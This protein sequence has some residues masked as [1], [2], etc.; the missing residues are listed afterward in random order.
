MKERAN[1]LEQEWWLCRIEREGGESLVSFSAWTKDLLPIIVAVLELEHPEAVV[2]NPKPAPGEKLLV[3]H[4]EPSHI[5]NGGT[6]EQIIK[7]HVQQQAPNL[8]T[9]LA[10]VSDYI[11]FTASSHRITYVKRLARMIHGL[12]QDPARIREL[13][14]ALG[15]EDILRIL[16]VRNLPLPG[17]PIGVK[18]PG[19]VRGVNG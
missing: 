5:L 6:W 8:E 7:A 9:H 11:H 2:E 19:P 3:V 10:W 14:R 15:R 17:S 18:F 12:M 1:S 16:P 4:V 13:L